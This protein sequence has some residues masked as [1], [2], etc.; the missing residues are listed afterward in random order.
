MAES[1][2]TAAGVVLHA[3]RDFTHLRRSPEESAH[4]EVQTVYCATIPLV[5]GLRLPRCQS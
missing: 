2:L 1:F 3:V 5:R 4:Q